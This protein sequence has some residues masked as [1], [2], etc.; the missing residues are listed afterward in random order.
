MSAST[1]AACFLRA[2][3]SSEAFRR[4]MLRLP[5]LHAPAVAAGAVAASRACFG[6]VAALLA[7]WYLLLCGWWLPGASAVVLPALE[8]L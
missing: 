5:I 8:W 1:L 4:T 6:P 2:A 7:T 3:P